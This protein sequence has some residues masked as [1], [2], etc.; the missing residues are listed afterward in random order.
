MKASTDSFEKFILAILV[1]LGFYLA[2]SVPSCVRE[3]QQFV[4]TERRV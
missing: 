2:F 3:H 1:F 4:K